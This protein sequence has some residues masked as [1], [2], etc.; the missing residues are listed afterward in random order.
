MP[1]DAYVFD[2][3]GTLFDVHAAARH[4]ADEIG[5]RATELSEIWRLKQLEYTWIRGTTGTYKP[6]HDVTADGLDY[7]IASIGGVTDGLRERLLDLYMKLD[8]YS[9]V[10][11]MLSGL[12]AAGKK[13][14][15][16]SNGSPKMLDAAVSSSGIGDV[17]DAVISVEDIQIYKPNFKVYKLVEK[18]LGVGGTA[19]S[20]QSSNRWDAAAAKAFGFRAVWCNRA[21]KPSE[22]DDMAPDLVVDNLMP[23]LENP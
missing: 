5:P 11:E 22:Y 19:V 2:A 3:Y 21:G 8:A 9:E 17:L 14:A 10:P 6:F 16:L 20:F 15:I 12:K 23:L 1:H 4:L 7:A 13:T 18:H